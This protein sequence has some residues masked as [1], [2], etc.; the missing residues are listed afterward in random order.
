MLSLLGGRTGVGNEEE[1]L[2]ISLPLLSTYVSTHIQETQIQTH[3]CPSIVPMS[4]SYSRLEE[5]D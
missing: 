4:N 5:T 3:V 2:S 1:N